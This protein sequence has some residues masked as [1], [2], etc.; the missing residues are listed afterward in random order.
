MN[1]LLHK[2]TNMP[3]KRTSTKAAA[4]AVSALYKGSISVADLQEALLRSPSEVNGITPAKDKQIY[5]LMYNY[6]QVNKASLS[7]SQL[8]SFSVSLAWICC[9]KELAKMLALVP[10]ASLQSIVSAAKKSGYNV[11]AA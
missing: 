5:E 11:K 8:D 7:R 2:E 1:T 3:T 9:G 4:E 6:L 10:D